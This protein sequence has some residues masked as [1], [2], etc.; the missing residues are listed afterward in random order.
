MDKVPMYYEAKNCPTE[1]P[2]MAL[3]YQVEKNSIVDKLTENTH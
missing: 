2:K 3:N 1:R